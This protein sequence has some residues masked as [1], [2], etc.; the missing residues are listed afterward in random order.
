MS[1]PSSRSSSIRPATKKNVVIWRLTARIAGTQT[2][3]V[4]SCRLR[5]RKQQSPDDEN[6]KSA[7]PIEA[8][9]RLQHDVPAKCGDECR[10]TSVLPVT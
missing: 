9:S 6:N 3:V 2:A 1:V 7:R 10:H 5:H 8:V 4:R